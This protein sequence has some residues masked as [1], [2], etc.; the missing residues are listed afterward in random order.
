[1]DDGGDVWR[2]DTPLENNKREVKDVDVLEVHGSDGEQQ[3]DGEARGEFEHPFRVCPCH[4]QAGVW[5]VAGV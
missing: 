5:Q 1:M 3:V 4:D 2:M